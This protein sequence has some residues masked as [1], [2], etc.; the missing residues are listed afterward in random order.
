M[1]MF[2]VFL[3]AIVSVVLATGCG[4]SGPVVEALDEVSGKVLLP[5]GKPLTAGTLVLRPAGGLSRPV[6]A[7]INQDGTFVLAGGAGEAPVL[8]GAYEVYLVFDDSPQQ[9][10]LQRV[11][12]T[13]YRKLNDEDS[14][15]SV[16]LDEG[17]ARDI[18]VKLK[19]G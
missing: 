19:R 2:Y 1:K 11:V 3:A 10:K 15:L 13:K 18:L 8:P 7:E 4:S 9:R 12:P 16:T 5:H 6:T 17:A 14:D